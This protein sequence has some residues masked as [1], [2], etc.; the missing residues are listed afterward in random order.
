MMGFLNV[1]KEVDNFCLLKKNYVKNVDI[2]SNL[3]IST[4]VKG[5]NKTVRALY[6]IVKN[7]NISEKIKFIRNKM[8]LRKVF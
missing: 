3:L 6:F 4:K 5:S 1:S 8:V 7:F 2:Y